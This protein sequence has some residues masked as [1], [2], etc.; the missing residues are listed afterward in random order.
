LAIDISFSKESQFLQ[1]L[2][3]QPY[4]ITIFKV[5][6]KFL[7]MDHQSLHSKPKM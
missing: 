6:R 5:F 4:G 2:L 7:P 1:G 3:A